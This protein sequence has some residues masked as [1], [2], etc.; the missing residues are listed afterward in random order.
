MEIDRRSGVPFYIQLKDQ[1][2]QKI[3]QGIWVVGT[4]L[5]TER[6]LAETLGVSRNT[7]S[8]AYKE[9]EGEGVLSSAQGRGTFVADTSLALQHESRK[10]KVL[11]IIDV[12]ME[13][14]VGLGFSIDDVVSFVHVRGM[15]KKAFLSRVKV[16]YIESNPEQLNDAFWNLGPGVSCIPLL[17]SD[18]QENRIRRETL[19]SLDMIITGATHLAEL[20]RLTSAYEIPVL[21]ISLQPK[22]ET[23]VRIA[24]LPTTRQVA[25]V[26]ESEN[27]AQKVKE[28]LDRAGLYPNLKVFLQPR[29]V[30]LR[31]ELD[32][33][34]A[35]ITIPSQKDKVQKALPENMELIEFRFEPDAGS[36]N[37]LRGELIDLKE[38]RTVLGVK[39]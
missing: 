16:G 12:A 22:L 4:K 39:I 20:K 2:R 7:I 30:G 34:A 13:E 24:K 27:F 33:C 25:L 23:I 6:E 38:K 21:G 28:Y 10:E 1:I 35:V 19:S 29:E 5:P 31:A 37:L 18:L 9:L 3:I 26:C 32:Q 15:E 8:Q 36:L 14:A 17:L 11:R